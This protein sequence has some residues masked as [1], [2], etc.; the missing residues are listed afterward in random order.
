M[1]VY[2]FT[3]AEKQQG[4]D[5]VRGCDVKRSCELLGVSRPAYYADAAT[6]AAAGSARPS[7][8]LS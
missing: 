1:N 2:P 7:R 4:G 8:T 3:G 6:Q 5:G